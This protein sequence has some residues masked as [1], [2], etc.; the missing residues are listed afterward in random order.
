MSAMQTWLPWILRL[1]WVATAAAGWTALVEATDDRSDPVRAVGTWGPTA[2]WVLGVAAM[3]VPAVATLTATRV[4]V[5]LAVPVAIVA[6]AG[7]AGAV[8]AG[9]FVAI[10]IA[11]ATIALS[12]DVGRAFVQASAYGAESRFPLRAPV[13]FVT[14]GVLAWVV[15]AALLV[16]GPLLLAA[17]SW[18]VGAPL[19][20]LAVVGTIG[21]TRRW[22]LLS[23][24]WLVLVP[25]G[26]VVHDPV[27]LGETIMLPTGQIAG[28]GLAPAGT[29]AL[30]LSG[31]AAGHAV[32]VRC[33]E[34]IT[35][36]LPATKERPTGKA[37]H[38]RSFL[39]TPTRPGRFLD[40]AA[41]R[42]LRVGTP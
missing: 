11:A 14:A 32:E 8:A 38:V 34:M 27:V 40:D 36:L 20:V 17:G 28:V 4:I 42:G 24:R 6:A 3:A 16:A 7:G 23:R 13:G 41:G 1:A 19:T 21:L 9:A 37:M 5:P 33:A 2:I 22:H 18:Y 30:D 15:W 29:E 35:A 39:V 12:A 26:L 10:A 31:P 25:A